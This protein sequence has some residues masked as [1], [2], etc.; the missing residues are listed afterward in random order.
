MQVS[1]FPA[2]IVVVPDKLRVSAYLHDVPNGAASIKCWS[3]VT[4]GLWLHRQKELVFT[5][6]VAPGE[7]PNN[8][9]E[10]PLQFFQLVYELAAKGKLVDAGGYTDF[11]E[12]GFL[13]RRAVG[14][15]DAEP[16]DAFASLS[17]SL[18]VILLTEDEYAAYEGFG[19]TRVQ[20]MLGRASRYFPCPPWNDRSRSSVVTRAALEKSKL[21]KVP[22]LSAPGATVLNEA[23]VVTLRLPF[24]TKYRIAK[25]VGALA[26]DAAAVRIP[27]RVPD[28]ADGCLVWVPGESGGAAIAA[29][30]ARPE[31]TS[32][33]CVVLHSTSKNERDEARIMEDGFLLSM[34]PTTWKGL[35]GALQRGIDHAFPAGKLSFA[36]KWDALPMVETRGAW[37][38]SEVKDLQSQVGGKALAAYSSALEE[39]VRLRLAKMNLDRSKQDLRVQVVVSPGAAKPAARMKSLPGLPQAADAAVGEAIEAVP[40]PAVKEPIAIE[41]LFGIWGGTGTTKILG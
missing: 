21:G 40:V 12:Q 37:I 38:V 28:A 33:C 23:G 6:Q 22:A 20:A 9:P 29:G 13:G 11:G 24:N 18:A 26:E 14:Y 34:T 2:G 31:R 25:D 3:Y 27:T 19:L 1:R 16:F 30:D 32:A 17:P 36:L 4:E 7:S 8:L 5:L 15:I 35:R 10:L 41:F 39:S